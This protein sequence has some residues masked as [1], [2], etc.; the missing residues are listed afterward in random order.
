MDPGFFRNHKNLR[1]F[2]NESEGHGEPSDRLRAWRGE[3]SLGLRQNPWLRIHWGWTGIFTGWWQLKEFLFSPRKLGKMNPFWLAYFSDGLVQP[4]T[5]IFTGSI[6]MV[7]FYGK[8]EC[9]EIILVP[10]WNPMGNVS[11]WKTPGWKKNHIDG[12][13]LK[14]KNS[15][16]NQWQ[17]CILCR[18]IWDTL[19]ETNIAP[20]NVWFW[21]WNSFWD[22]PFSGAMLVSGSVYGRHWQL[23]R[24]YFTYLL[25]KKDMNL[26]T[27][28]DESWKKPYI[29][30]IADSSGFFPSHHETAFLR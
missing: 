19:P 5:S 7:D 11:L 22:G 8:C 10:G 30:G 16:L 24:I 1:G 26:S 27:P 3:D 20:E 29:H 12:Q 4:P 2:W 6:F 17:V 25:K 18:K 21:R 23:L 9:R 15:R 13:A 28:I 14:R